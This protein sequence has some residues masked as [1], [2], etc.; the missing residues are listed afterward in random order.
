MS[1]CVRVSQ[2]S[3]NGTNWMGSYQKISGIT[4]VDDCKNFA[5]SNSIDDTAWY[6]NSGC[7][8]APISALIVP[9]QQQDNPGAIGGIVTCE[10]KVGLFGN[11]IILL[12]IVA[13]AV[14]FFLWMKS[15]K[16]CNTFN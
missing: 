4:S 11:I 15:C 5:I 10:P 8:V 3:T 16:K 13:I 1:D 6:Y 9:I 2:Y 14:L 7:F 12:I